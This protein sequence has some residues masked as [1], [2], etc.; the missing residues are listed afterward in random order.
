MISSIGHL[1]LELAGTAGVAVGEPEG[2]RGQP[3]GEVIRRV[4]VPLPEHPEKGRAT[5]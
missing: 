3:L 2:A 4:G 5:R 1:D